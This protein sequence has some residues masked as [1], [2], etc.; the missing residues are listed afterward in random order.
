MASP[1][2]A[3]IMLVTLLAGE[4]EALLE[5]SAEIFGIAS[6]GASYAG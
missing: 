3:S 5:A 6:F 2:M 1:A 4:G